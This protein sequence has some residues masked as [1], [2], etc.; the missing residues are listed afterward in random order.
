MTQNNPRNITLEDNI[1]IID[2]K[3]D[4]NGK[5]IVIVNPSINQNLAQQKIEE[6]K[7]IWNTL[8][9]IFTPNVI[10]SPREIRVAVDASYNAKLIENIR[11][12][13]GSEAHL[14]AVVRT[15]GDFIEKEGSNYV[16]GKFYDG[17]N[18]QYTG[19]I[20]SY[21]T[22]KL[23][24]SINNSNIIA[25]YLKEVFVKR[26]NNNDTKSQLYLSEEGNVFLL[27][28]EL[29]MTM[30]LSDKQSLSADK[31]QSFISD[32]KALGATKFEISV[33]E[34][35]YTIQPPSFLDLLAKSLGTTSEIIKTNNPWIKSL[36]Q[37]WVL[38][39]GK[40]LTIPTSEVK[41]SVKLENVTIKDKSGNALNINNTSKDGTYSNFFLDQA[42]K[43]LLTNTELNS[44]WQ[45]TSN[46]T[47]SILSNTRLEF[48]FDSLVN[49]VV[50]TQGKNWDGKTVIDNSM[51]NLDVS[52]NKAQGFANGN[53]LTQAGNVIGDADWRITMPNDIL[54][55]D[56][57]KNVASSAIVSD[58][59]RPAAMELSS[60]VNFATLGYE[61]NDVYGRVVKLISQGNKSSSF[62]ITAAVA[63]DNW[64]AV[65]DLCALKN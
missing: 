22:D 16:L 54:N 53:S 29:K 59:F 21:V 41:S 31:A 44:K 49:S 28:D 2:I 14:D 23:S 46:P 42:N 25:K 45:V 13:L 10:S 37:Y 6:I 38:D 12:G 36:G 27:N 48:D 50:G 51:L 3:I 58:F 65:N 47:S 39:S 18:S 24:D 43:T 34:Q 20:M 26:A 30:V 40:K 32:S 52:T 57:Y 33:N 1:A 64:M 35:I 4:A 56:G 8:L 17:P 60:Y 62:I 9:E 5:A 55:G 11:N 7:S 19:P 15:T 61:F 63:N